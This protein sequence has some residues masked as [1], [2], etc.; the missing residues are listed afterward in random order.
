MGLKQEAAAL[1]EQLIL[2]MAKAKSIPIENIQRIIPSPKNPLNLA[3]CIVEL[4]SVK[5]V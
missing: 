5:K 1:N 3:K 2:D 4:R